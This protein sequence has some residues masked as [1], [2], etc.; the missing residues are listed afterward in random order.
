MILT[1]SSTKFGVVAEC[2]WVGA[3]GRGGSVDKSLVDKR[4]AGL[5]LRCPDC[6]AP[7][8]RTVEFDGI[9]FTQRIGD[10]CRRLPDD[11][12]GRQGW[13]AKHMHPGRLA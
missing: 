4:L 2:I 1:C 11:E 8:V 12:P 7:G 13:W 9:V 5:L 3:R 6:G 10:P